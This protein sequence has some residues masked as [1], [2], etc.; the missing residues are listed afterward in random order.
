MAQH[1]VDDP[2]LPGLLGIHEIVPF[3]VARHGFHRLPRMLRQQGVE[4]LANDQ[5]LTRVDVDV[6]GLAVG[7]AAGL[8][9]MMREFGSA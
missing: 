3:R 4:P 5:D 2:V 6:R 1:L 7:A 9:I 8:V